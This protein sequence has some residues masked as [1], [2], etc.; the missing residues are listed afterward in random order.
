MQ[1]E[2]IP[3]YARDAL[4]IKIVPSSIY[5]LKRAGLEIYSNKP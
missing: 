1:E 2:P 4:R 5:V 3:G